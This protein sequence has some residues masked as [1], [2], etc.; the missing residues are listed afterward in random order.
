MEIG[1]DASRATLARRT[2]TETYSLELLRALIAELDETATDIRLRLY[3]NQPPAPG[4]LP[5]SP[6]VE[7]QVMPW[8][9]L[10]THVRLS[11]E[12][13]VHPPDVL[14]VPAH[15]LPAVAPRRS[16]VTIHDLGHL[17]FP[18]EYPARAWALHWLGTQYNARRA[19]HLLADSYATRRDLMRYCRVSEQKISVVHL[20]VGARF[21]PDVPLEA[22]AAVRERLGLPPEYLLFVGTLQPRKNLRRLVEAYALARERHGLRLPLLLAGQRGWLFEPIRRRVAELGLEPHIHFPGY[23]DSADLPALLAGARAFV[24]P[25]LFEGFGLPALEALACGVP[26]LVSHSGSLPEVVGDAAIQV[27]PRSVDQIAAGIARLAEDE[28][29][30]GRLRAAGPIQAARF[31]WR[32][33]ARETLAVLRAVGEGRD[34][35]PSS[36]TPGAPGAEAIFPCPLGEG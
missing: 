36:P 4:L 9:R 19:H 29:L 11:G 23:I 22:R 24:L 30:A 3:F 12:L 21:R 35:G 34:G 26:T 8:P 5:R 2:G 10:W 20:A 27:D 25:S 31:S 18:R 16:L 15:L 14:F 28:A 33:C 17:Y 13:A 7:R 1:I 32:R 6:R